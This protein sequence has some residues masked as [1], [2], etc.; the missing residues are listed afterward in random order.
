MSRAERRKMLKGTS[1]LSPTQ[2]KLDDVKDESAKELLVAICRSVLPRDADRW[3]T[4]AQLVES[5]YD[6]VSAG[7]LDVHI[8]WLSDGVDVFSEL[9]TPGKGPVSLRGPYPAVRH[10]GGLH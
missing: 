8:R 3:F 2:M 1:K 5:V 7:F 6:L 4:D 10:A 9:K